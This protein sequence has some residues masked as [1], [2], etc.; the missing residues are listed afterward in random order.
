MRYLRYVMSV[1]MPISLIY[2]AQVVTIEQIQGHTSSSPYN[3]QVVT[4]YGVVTGIYVNTGVKGFTLEEKS[5]ASGP[6]HGIF[7]YTGVNPIV[8]VGDSVEVTGLVEE[9]YDLTEL[10]GDT[11]RI[12]ASGVELPAPYIT[13]ADSLKQEAFEGVLITLQH[14]VCES[15]PNSYGEWWVNDGTASIMVDDLGWT[16]TGITLGEKY[17]ITGTIYY[18][19]RKYKIEP[20]G[21]YDVVPDTANTPP[22]VNLISFSPKLPESDQMVRVVFK[23]VDRDMGDSIVSDT[24]FISTDSFNTVETFISILDSVNTTIDSIQDDSIFV[25]Y[26]PR[27]PAGTKVYFYLKVKDS[28]GGETLS[29]VERYIVNPGDEVIPISY[30]HILDE[31]GH[32]VFLGKNVKIQGIVT[33]AGDFGK[34]Y[35]MQDRTGG[36]VL[37]NPGT[38]L[39]K[40]DSV[41]ITGYVTEY[42]GV[43]ELNNAIA[44]FKEPGHSVYPKTV[45]CQQLSEGKEAYEGMFVQIFH[46][47]TP[48]TIFVG[49]STITIN[50]GTGTYTLYVDPSTD[51]AG[52]PIPQGEMTIQGVIS[53]YDPDSSDGYFDGYQIVPRGIKDIS[54]SGNGSGKFF[55]LPPYLHKG[56]T[57]ILTFILTKDLAPINAARFFLDTWAD[58]N[59][60][61]V[62]GAEF[63]KD[64][65]YHLTL[66]DFTQETVKIHLKAMAPDS[67]TIFYITLKTSAVDTNNLQETLESPYRLFVTTPIKDAQKPGDDGVTPQ[68]TGKVVTLAGVVIG[69]NTKFSGSMTNLWIQ[70]D[71]AGIE[72]FYPQAI[73]SFDTGDV[74]VVKGTIT[75]YNGLT[76]IVPE[77]SSD[78]V[79]AGHISPPSPLELKPSE[80]IKESLEG[81]LITFEGTLENTPYVQGSGYNMI[82]WNGTAPITVYVY[83]STGINVNGLKKGDMVKITGI[84]GQYDY[85]PPYND[86]YQVLPR[87]QDDISILHAQSSPTVSLRVSPNV[88]DKIKDGFCTIYVEGPQN[89]NYTLKIYNINGEV[90]KDIYGTRRIGPANAQWRLDDSQGKIV[91]IGYYIVKVDVLLPD[92]KHQSVYKPVVVTRPK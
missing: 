50:D 79:Y 32:S 59:S 4:T 25:Y 29:D 47:T 26:I 53:Q 58:M 6:W 81:V 22:F 92:G 5:P 2:A 76:E 62:E 19:Y 15:L 21:A 64:N 40:G 60:I 12:L 82:V 78:I 67:E 24:L 8:S 18:S 44:L 86:G 43:V 61:S 55:I 54:A 16:P 38:P 31:R 35:Y 41:V 71:T 14:A 89:G 57:T 17:N 7:V 9:Y 10:H 75:E 74:V 77:N 84:A 1:I 63:T 70:D 27:H 30:L 52:K 42:N 85:T 80:G 13:T 87:F 34:K 45:T 56:D 39:V 65:Y 3:G 11:I 73:Q 72:I 49:G 36:V 69:P 20:R 37:Y 33:V 66:Y 88:V 46:V 51:L 91:P 83:K 68:D 23:A 90:I 48:D 28:H